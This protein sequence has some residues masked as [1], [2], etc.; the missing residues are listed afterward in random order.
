MAAFCDGG[1]GYWHLPQDTN[2]RQKPLVFFWSSGH[3]GTETLAK[4]LRKHVWS[5]HADNCFHHTKVDFEEHPMNRN[6]MH[7]GMACN[8]WTSLHQ[9]VRM[10]EQFV[11]SRL[12]FHNASRYVHI[13]HDLDISVIHEVA[14]LF[15]D[16]V[17]MIR[18]R[19]DRIYTAASISSARKNPCVLFRYAPCPLRSRVTLPV[20]RSA[21]SRFSL[22]QRN[23]WLQDEVEC[24]W[25]H[26]RKVLPHNHTIEI[27]WSTSL[28]NEHLQQILAFLRSPCGVHPSGRCTLQ[29]RRGIGSHRRKG[30]KYDVESAYAQ[31]RE[32]DLRYQRIMREQGPAYSMCFD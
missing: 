14:W 29:I 18:I 10:Y 21:W 2:L 30:D 20:A 9:S 5:S 17:Y 7:T 6:F 16:S 3:S 8:N 23:L 22:F 4:V 24:Q 15:N 25:L 13:G 28:N 12:Q 11:Q 26:L 31:L 19:R 32:Q 27:N 1:R